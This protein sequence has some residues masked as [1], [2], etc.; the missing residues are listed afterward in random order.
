MASVR[1]APTRA[2]IVVRHTSKPRRKFTCTSCFREV[3]GWEYLVGMGYNKI[4]ECGLCWAAT[5]V[6]PMKPIGFGVVMG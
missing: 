5:R 6:P 2:P 3:E 4:S 1:P